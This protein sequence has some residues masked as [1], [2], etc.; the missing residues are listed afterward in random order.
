MQVETNIKKLYIWRE[1]IGGCY[2]KKKGLPHS[3]D[4]LIK[5]SLLVQGPG[6]WSSDVCSSDL[7]Y[8]VV[9]LMLF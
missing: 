6:D 4:L 3:V 5:D 7:S 9:F 8:F 2:V 1:G